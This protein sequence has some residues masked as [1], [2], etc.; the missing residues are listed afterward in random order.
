MYVFIHTH[1]LVYSFMF[2][3]P[4]TKTFDILGTNQFYCLYWTIYKLKYHFII[5]ETWRSWKEEPAPARELGTR[6]EIFKAATGTAAGSSGDGANTNGQHWIDPINDFRTEA[7]EVPPSLLTSSER[8]SPALNG[9]I[10]KCIVKNVFI[11]IQ[12]RIHDDTLGV[13]CNSASFGL[14]I[15]HWLGK[16]CTR[17]VRKEIHSFHSQPQASSQ[18]QQLT[19]NWSQQLRTWTSNWGLFLLDFN[20][21]RFQGFWELGVGTGL[22]SGKT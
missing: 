1:I 15:V 3:L 9:S 7:R 21:G 22:F 20:G 13:Y 5:L 4:K 12:C 16:L 8:Y 14:L 10:F 17:E 19:S 11:Q 6:T 2:S 18:S